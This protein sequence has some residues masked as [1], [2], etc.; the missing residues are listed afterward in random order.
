MTRP[1]DRAQ[2]RSRGNVERGRPRPLE[3]HTFYEIQF[4][5]QPR[6]EIG[7]QAAGG[8]NR[9]RQ[10]AWKA[11]TEKYTSHTKEATSAC[12]EKKLAYMRTEPGQHLDMFSFLGEFTTS[13]RHGA[14]GS[15]RTIREHKCSSSS[16]PLQEGAKYKLRETELWTGRHPGHT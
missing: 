8:W 1:H 11:L 4:R 2:R 7:R 9:K 14:S 5:Q 10:A 16:S 13:Q 15:R 12:Y 3:N 6:Q